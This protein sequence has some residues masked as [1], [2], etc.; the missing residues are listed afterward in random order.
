MEGKSKTQN[1]CFYQIS[2]QQQLEYYFSDENLSKD[3]FLHEKICNNPDGYIPINIILDFNKVKNRGSTF[4]DVI[5]AVNN[6]SILELSNDNL[7]IRRLETMKLPDLESLGNKRLF[8]YEISNN[9]NNFSSILNNNISSNLNN[10]IFSNL[11]N[12]SSFIK[13]VDKPKR[14]KNPSLKPGHG[15]SKFQAKHKNLPEKEIQEKW[16]LMDAN[17][18]RPYKKL[19]KSEINKKERESLKTWIGSNFYKIPSGN[20]LRSRGKYLYFCNKCKKRCEEGC[21]YK[22]DYCN[23]CYWKDC[24]EDCSMSTIS[25]KKCNISHIVK[26]TADHNK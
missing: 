6:S 18:R 13:V 21:E 1:S 10:N 9:N 23:R 3:H 12:I 25:C 19:E 17:L 15:Y 24:G 4:E 2:L 7:H 8:S 16:F 14:K 22:G 20:P 11:N 5:Q 26:P